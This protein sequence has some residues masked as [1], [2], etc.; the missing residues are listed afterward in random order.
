[1]NAYPDM[2]FVKKFTH[3]RFLKKKFDRKV[4]KSQWTQ[5]CNKTV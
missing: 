4:N 3:A 5:D 2:E 1:M